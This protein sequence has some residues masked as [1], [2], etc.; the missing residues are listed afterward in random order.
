M[1][2]DPLGRESPLPTKVLDGAVEAEPAGPEF[3][4]AI[5]FRLAIGQVR[6]FCQQAFVFLSVALFQEALRSPPQRRPSP[7]MTKGA[8]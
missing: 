3:G 4:S 2:T 7:T 8:Q 1:L 6:D 5:G